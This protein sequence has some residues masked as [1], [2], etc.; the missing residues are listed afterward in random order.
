MSRYRAR[1]AEAG[2][3]LPVALIVLLLLG[4]LALALVTLAGLE[5]AVARNLAD[6]TRARLLAEAGLERAR[7]ALIATVDWT[8]L[9]AG[10]AA[11]EAVLIDAT[12]LPG[13][14][15]HE[16]THTVRV[17]NDWQTADTALTGLVPD[18]GGRAADTNDHVLV[19]STGQA[20]RARRTVL[21]VARRLPLPSPPAAVALTGLEAALALTDD[22]VEIDGRDHAAD[23]SPGAC[24]PA[25]AVAVEHPEAEAAVE[26]AVPAALASRL[27]GRAQDDGLAAEGPNTIAADGAL[28]PAALAAFVEAVRR[29]R[30]VVIDARG[31]AVAVTDVGRGCGLEPRGD[32]CWGTPERPKVV[33]VAGPA[34][35]DAVPVLEISGRG[36]G[37]GV[38]VIEHGA[39]RVAGDFRWR[40]LVIVTGRGAGLEFAGGGAQTVLGGVVIDRTPAGGEAGPGFA[41]G[42]A[43]VLRSCEA[44]DQAQRARRLVTLQGWQEVPLY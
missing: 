12:P 35:G 22:G 4:A 6:A 27:R 34:P 11:E 37:Y 21:A 20:G 41:P 15:A 31:G 13:L 5:P 28:A 40:G 23:G 25:W 9:L 3:V 17:R 14:G 8:D 42:P 38:L 30:D 19:V 2:V 26:A 1:R 29:Q 43:R 16:G 33:Y 24:A 44:L 10:G 36:E 32:D 39:A 18:P 7:G